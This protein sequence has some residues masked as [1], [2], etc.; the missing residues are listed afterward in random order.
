MTLKE[1]KRAY[2]KDGATVRYTASQMARADRIDAK[3]AK[4]KKEV[5][6]DK[7][8]VE[9]KRKR[10]E[11]EDKERSVR[12][13]MLDE[14]R[15]TLED[16]W[17]KV[18]ASQPRL[19]QFFGRRSAATP[20]KSSLRIEAVVDEEKTVVPGDGR[21]PE[22]P[23]QEDFAQEDQVARQQDKSTID[24]DDVKWQAMDLAQSLEKE[25]PKRS[26]RNLS[27]GA[28]PRRP[29]SSIH[30]QPS[31]LRQLRPSQV[32]ARSSAPARSGQGFQQGPSL[33]SIVAPRIDSRA[34]L[35][36]DTASLGAAGHSPQ[37]TPHS[38]ESHTLS[39]GSP[40]E[41]LPQNTDVGQH[42]QKRDHEDTLR[43]CSGSEES[44]QT[45]SL[46]PQ[47]LQVSSLDLTDEED[48]TDGIDDDTFLMLCATQRPARNAAPSDKSLPSTISALSTSIPASPMLEVT[49]VRDGM[50]IPAEIAA[51]KPQGLSESFT[52]VFNEIEDEDLLA[53]A[54]EVEAQA[55]PQ[56]NLR[57][58]IM[59]NAAKTDG[60]VLPAKQRQISL[61]ESSTPQLSRDRQVMPGSA[62]LRGQ[63]MTGPVHKQKALPSNMSTP[64]KAQDTTESPAWSK[65]VAAPMA[66]E[67]SVLFNIGANQ[68]A[69]DMSARGPATNARAQNNGAQAYTT[70]LYAK[71]STIP[72]QMPP[73]TKKPY[74][75]QTRN[76]STKSSPPR[77]SKKRIWPCDINPVDEFLSL[78]PSTQ[79]SCLEL[80]EQVEAQ[81]EHESRSLRSR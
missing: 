41:L 5:E 79:A 36:N 46:D 75:A 38:S 28:V 44:E 68:Q 6:K 22:G 45:T 26:G 70:I 49:G 63:N 13:K 39:E 76:T 72:A 58:T 14:G 23:E 56:Q 11:K 16:T 20:A 24:V 33:K 73:P 71:N 67:G 29:A 69:A 25:L 66:T 3:E 2:K 53:L 74:P 37:H 15:I 60:P 47:R 81:I 64:A 35:Q 30:S 8:K 78:G 42:S 50:Q 19:N 40:T 4:R 7:Q 9:N 59:M 12:Q 43:E 65:P 32:N 62:S 10:E 57:S 21:A 17:G 1:A 80:L 61:P 55:T 51:H 27:L 52:S 54:E 18:T 48:F 31:A 77:K 34:S